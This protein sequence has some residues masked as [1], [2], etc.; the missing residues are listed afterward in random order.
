MR[1]PLEAPSRESR[2]RDAVALGEGS[3][4]LVVAL[5]A[6]PNPDEKLEV[7]LLGTFSGG[8]AATAAVGCARLG[9]R[10]AFVGSTGDD[11][12][13]ETLVAS[14]G[15]E[16]V[17]AEIVVRPGVPTRSAVVLLT[18][19]GRR[20]ILE[21]CDGRLRLEPRELPLDVLTGGRVLMT[22]GVH[23]RAS[24]AAARTAR[25]AGI[26]TVVD[27]DRASPDADALLAEAD[28]LVV[29][30]QALADLSG[31]D[32]IG[33]GLRR[34]SG[35]PGPVLT[36]VTLGADGSLARCRDREFRTAAPQVE[37]TDTTGA[38]DAFRA[39]LVAG[40]LTADSAPDVE[41]LLRSANAVAALNCRRIGAQSGLPTPAELARFL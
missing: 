19:E 3:I 23:G 20:T 16:G 12:N 38:G 17:A 1:L 10:A 36:V 15:A 22:D 13:A 11:A 33:E 2:A 37:V 32:G 7:D 24:A 30:V 39:G 29:P 25:A 4:D 34:L 41:T 8:Q 18:P 28:V 14:L 6:W 5:E 21:S 31:S 9:L 27:V 40:W 35:R 26:P